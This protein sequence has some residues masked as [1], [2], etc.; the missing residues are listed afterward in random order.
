MQLNGHRERLPAEL[1]GV[2]V[3]VGARAQLACDDDAAPQ[4][5]RQVVRLLGEL[6]EG[7]V[8]GRLDVDGHGV[9]DREAKL[10]AELLHAV[11]HLAGAG[12]PLERLVAREVEQH[13][14]LAGLGVEPARD[15]DVV[16]GDPVAE[17][18]GAALRLEG[19]NLGLTEGLDRRA[20]LLHGR[21]EAG[22]ERL[23]VGRDLAADARDVA[24]KL[25][26]HHVQLV[27]NQSLQLADGR[28][29]A[30]VLVDHLETRDGGLQGH[31]AALADGAPQQND[32]LHCAD[33]A[34]YLLVDG[35]ADLRQ[36]L[37]VDALALGGRGALEVRVDHLGREGREHAHQP[38]EGVE[39][40][41][42]RRERDEGIVLPEGPAHAVA[43][44]P[45]VP[46]GQLLQEAQQLRQDVV[47]PVGGH[48]A[49][50]AV[51]ELL[52]DGAEPPVHDARGIERGPGVGD[53]APAGGALIA[54]R[55]L[56]Q[57]PVG[58]EPRQNDVFEDAADALGEEAKRLRAHGGRGDEVQADA[59]GAVLVDDLH[60]VGEVLE[61]LRHLLAV[62]RENEPVHDDV[63]EGRLPEEVRRYHHEG[64]EPATGLVQALGDEV[65]GEVVFEGLAVLEGV[66]HLG[67]GHRAA[68]VPAVEDF[69]DAAQ[70]LELGAARVRDLDVVHVVP[71]QV[72]Y[73]AARVTLQLRDAA[74]A[75]HLGVVL[76]D[77]QG[78]GRAPEAV[79]AHAPV[80][81]VGDPVA[82]PLLLHEAGHP[83]GLLDAAQDF[84]AV[85]LHLDEPAAHRAV[86]EGRV[87]AP[88]EG[89]GVNNGAGVDHAR[90]LLQHA[91]DLGV[92]VLD[93]H[94]AE[95]LQ[96]GL[97]VAALVDQLGQRSAEHA[98][99]FAHLHILLAKV[100]VEDPLGVVAEALHAALCHHQVHVALDVVQHHVDELGVDDQR[101]VRGQRPW[102]RGPRDKLEGLID[103][104][105]CHVNGGVSDVLVVEVG[106]EV[107]HRRG[108]RH[109][110]GH[111]LEPPVNHPFFE[112]LLEDPPQRLH[113]ARV[114]RLVVVVEVDPTAGAR[115]DLAPLRRIPHDDFSA[116]HTS[117]QKRYP[118]ALLVVDPDSHLQHIV[119]VLDVVGLVDLVFD[120][121]PVAVPAETALNTVAGLCF[122]EAE[123]S[124]LDGASQDM[125]IVRQPR[126][127]G[128][129]VVEGEAGFACCQLVG[130][131]EDVDFIPVPQDRLLFLGE[132]D[133]FV[134]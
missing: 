9:V 5:F 53:E 107:G 19:L 44:D 32:L 15:H 117:Q 60:G 79:A 16:Q 72:V 23:E 51:D 46:V 122:R 45:D 30:L 11:G 28:E 80:A 65:G 8:A 55:L 134:H 48:L 130:G 63:A 83:L 129:A 75:D 58:V 109:R 78:D 126:G 103:A 110:V 39:R 123:W 12:H 10:L 18:L 41:V 128:R 111:Y 133:P 68:L 125:A 69:G 105:E 93:E 87:A 89:I 43:I 77:P 115:N 88:A 62:A 118:P 1:E 74:D 81:G 104:P 98:V 37:E 64:V 40:R 85:V 92:R 25:D 70:R 84:R 14:H 50:H 34:R 91:L 59:V 7:R 95:P 24:R 61:A 102:G 113:V 3:H 21:A 132:V 52:G 119:E 31:A 22:A 4:R 96:V 97:E 124:H 38:R 100:L 67:V 90:A 54:R 116:L 13:R 114:E 26:A 17:N 106:L 108:A 71:V 112:Q 66:V 127:E 2:D 47:E 131:V 33:L 120:G 35:A 94:P 56:N 82:E 36:H 99:L 6:L 57:E 27:L 20:H 76:A 121:Q 29:D 73:L 42:Q 49:V 86:D 101:Q